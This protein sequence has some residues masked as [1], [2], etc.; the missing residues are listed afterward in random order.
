M[1]QADMT[2]LAIAGAVLFAGYKYGNGMVKAGC[3]A[4]AAG[5]IAKRVPYVKDVL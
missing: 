5:V 2:K 1:T 3:V 4:V